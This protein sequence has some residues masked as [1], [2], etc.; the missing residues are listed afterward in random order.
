MLGQY[1]RSIAFTPRKKSEEFLKLSDFTDDLPEFTMEEAKRGNGRDGNN[2][3]VM[4]H[5]Y[6][7]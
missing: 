5:L 6:H 3:I 4:A 7:R 2:I 1:L